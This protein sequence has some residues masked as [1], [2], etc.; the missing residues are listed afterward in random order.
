MSEQS[1][2]SAIITILSESKE[3]LHY[4]EITER[5]MTR[6]LKTTSGATPD[7]TV[8]AQISSSIKHDG[9]ASPFLRVAKGT[10]TLRSNG[11]VAAEPVI[12]PEVETSDDV[13]AQLYPKEVQALAALVPDWPVMLCRHEVSNKLIAAYLDDIGLGAKCA[14]SA[15]GQRIAKYSL[16]T[17]INRFVWR[18][19]AGLRLSVT[20]MLDI[21][22]IAAID[23]DVLPKLTKANAKVWA[24]KALM[25]YV[26][27]MYKNFSHVP[28]FSAILRRPAVRTRGQ[29]RREIRKD[30]IRALQSLAPPA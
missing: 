20:S 2:K 19:L 6:G 28:E 10:F 25:P 24:D 7:A 18:K 5:I 13:T 22:E 21:P 8:N 3:P 29:Q 9:T 30:I 1:W 14:I 16:R 15:D 17:P 11:A 26:T 4:H 12:E 27:A 23:L